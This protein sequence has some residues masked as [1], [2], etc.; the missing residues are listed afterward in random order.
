MKA[1]WTFWQANAPLAPSDATGKRPGQGVALTCSCSAPD[2][3]MAG[4]GLALVRFWPGL[5]WPC[6]GPVQGQ[7]GW[8]GRGQGGHR[9]ACLSLPPARRLNIA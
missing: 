4:H 5:P 3:G 6:A 8:L 7:A 2:L 1:S 9:P